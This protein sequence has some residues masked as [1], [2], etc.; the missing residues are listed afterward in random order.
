MK[1]QDIPRILFDEFKEGE[2]VFIEREGSVYQVAPLKCGG[3]KWMIGWY[4]RQ[5]EA[6]ERSFLLVFKKSFEEPPI[7]VK[8]YEL[9]RLA[10]GPLQP[11]GSDL[12][13]RDTMYLHPIP[14]SRW[15]ESSIALPVTKILARAAELF[16]SPQCEKRTYV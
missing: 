12:P 16:H 5:C 2:E 11:L 13:A 6:G 4:S 1:V 8:S 10:Y 9:I 3:G 14:D 15:L 7:V